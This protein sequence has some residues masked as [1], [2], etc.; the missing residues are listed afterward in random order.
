MNLKPLNYHPLLIKVTLLILLSLS[1]VAT[2]IFSFYSY[3]FI[4]LSALIGILISFLPLRDKASTTDEL[5]CLNKCHYKLL[6]IFFLLFMTLVIISLL[7]SDFS[8]P[9]LYYFGISLCSLLLGME[10]MLTTKARSPYITLFKI[11]LLCLALF[12]S[13]QVVYPLGIGGSDAHVHFP[14][15]ISIIET[16]RILPNVVYSFTPLH[17]LLV[18]IT[19]LISSLDF[20]FLYY[21]L[22]AFWMSINLPLIFLVGKKYINTEFGLIASLIYPFNDYLLF[23]S[24]HSAQLTYVLPFLFFTFTLILFRIDNPK[25][26][27][28]IVLLILIPSIIFAHH[29]SSMFFIFILLSF[30]I[31]SR[32][33]YLVGRGKCL[34]LSNITILFCIGLFSHWMYYSHLIVDFAHILK[35]YLDAVT[36]DLIV[37][38]SSFSQATRYDSLPLSTIFLN[39]FGSNILIMLSAYGF[40]LFAQKGGLFRNIIISWMLIIPILIVTGIFIDLRFFLPNRLY[41][42]MQ[43]F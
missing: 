35:A 18:T 19:S 41:V 30:L 25:F 36:I 40:I 27:Y 14:T 2:V 4:I 3:I 23:W 10:I 11:Y 8:K 31:G 17:H 9:W 7:I 12:F 26:G 13:N 15:I 33:C 22:G 6:D 39:T 21:V 5:L 37:H 28:T 1:L 43:L 20:K 32:L 42:F 29:Y 24:T 16:G 38:Q 34:N